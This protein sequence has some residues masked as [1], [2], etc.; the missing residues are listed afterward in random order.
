[1]I[2]MTNFETIQKQNETESNKIKTRIRV[3]NKKKIL[4]YNLSN[5]IGF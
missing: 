5:K 4:F 2:K 1:M 3:N